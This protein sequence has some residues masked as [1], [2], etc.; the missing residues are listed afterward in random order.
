MLFGKKST[1]ARLGGYP[2]EPI[3]RFVARNYY[4]K[5][6]QSIKIL[7]FGCG[8]GAHTWYLAREG[9]DTYAF[10]GSPSAVQKAQEKLDKEGLHAHFS[11]IDG[12][13]L[14][15]ENFF[16]AVID[17]ACI[18]ANT[19]ASIDIMF[20]NVYKALKNGGKF[21]TTCFGK[22]LEGYETGEEIEK[23]TYINIKKG[24]LTNRGL[25]H[26]YDEYELI[27]RLEK[28]G[29]VNI[30]CDWIKYADRGLLVHQY[31]CTA[32]KNE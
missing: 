19:S 6:R 5:E 18:Y 2:A 12:I 20:E 25:S 4:S 28:A 7:D 24:V 10:D 14:D 13:N 9:F 1:V 8:Q 16:D 26:I 31:V 15:Y 21:L 32:E 27:S 17:S 22:E 11:V 3:I 30:T 29:F 23:G